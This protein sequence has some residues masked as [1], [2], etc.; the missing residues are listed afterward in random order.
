MHDHHAVLLVIIQFLLI[1][2][3]AA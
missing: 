1:L 3:L 2:A